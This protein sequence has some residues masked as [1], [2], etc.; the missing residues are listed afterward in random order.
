M[1]ED[2][3]VQLDKKVVDDL[4]AT[5]AAPQRASEMLA[6]MMR[7]FAEKTAEAEMEAWDT[8][9]EMCGADK[10]KEE[11]RVNWLTAKATITKRSWVPYRRD[12]SA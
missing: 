3:V 2:R 1:A 6:D 5:L 10:D 7:K 11:V 12:D 8:I 4:H 9:Y